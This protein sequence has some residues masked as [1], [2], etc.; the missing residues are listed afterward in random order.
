MS[1]FLMSDILVAN[2]GKY[3]KLTPSTTKASK[4]NKMQGTNT[5][6]AKSKGRRTVQQ[7]LMSWSNR[8][9]GKEA[10]TQINVKTKALDFIPKIRPEINPLVA[11]DLPE[12]IQSYFSSK[13]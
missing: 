5:I 8:I 3:N 12:D 11:I 1:D 2:K 10:R 4:L 6:K 13:A 7:K 9:L